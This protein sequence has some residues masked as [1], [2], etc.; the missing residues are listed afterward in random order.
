[1]GHRN[2]QGLYF[3]KENN[4]ILETEHGPRGGDEIN[5]IEIENIKENAILNY[6]WAIASYGEHYGGRTDKNK[7]KYKRYPLHKSHSEYGYIEPLKAFV[8]SIGISEITKNGEN[9][10]LTSSMGSD[11]EGDKSIYFF[12]LSKEKKLIN[13][14]KVKVTQRVRDL[15][16]KNNSLFLFFDEPSAIGLIS[17]N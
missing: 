15:K 11:R 16:Y 5:L 13:L 10:F 17:L 3:D 14:K 9:E 6:G 8:P 4:F 12:E 1:M 7:E 2:P